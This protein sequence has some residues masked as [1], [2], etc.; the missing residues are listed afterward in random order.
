MALLKPTS[1]SAV[2][3]FVT[4]HRKIWHQSNSISYR[5]RFST[6]GS[7]SFTLWNDG[8]ARLVD[9]KLAPPHSLSKLLFE[10]CMVVANESA[11]ESSPVQCWNLHLVNLD[12]IVESILHT[13]R[14]FGYYVTSHPIFLEASTSAVG[15]CQFC[16]PVQVKT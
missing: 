4:K 16:R 3:T 2:L 1:S 6:P 11:R 14:T 10:H 5:Y 7:F 8:T 12:E 9:T 13:Q 15:N